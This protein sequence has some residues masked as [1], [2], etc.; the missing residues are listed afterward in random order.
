MTVTQAAIRKHLS[1]LTPNQR[2]QLASLATPRVVEPYTKHIPHPTQQVFLSLNIEE[3]LYGGAAGG[4]KSDALLMAALQY[5]DVPGY[6]AL[7]LRRTWPDLVLPGAIMDRTKQWLL[8]TDARP[9]DGGRSWT[10]PSGAKLQFGYLA[11]D[12]DKY[13][14]QSAEFQ[15]VGF[16]ELTQWP[17]ETTYDYLFSRIRRPAINCLGCNTTLG[18]Y[19]RS[20]G[21]VQYKH[22]TQEGR[23]RCKK[24]FPDPKVLSQYPQSRD[25]MSVFDIPLRMRAATNPGGRG[26]HWVKARFVDP[27]TRARGA[28]F[29]PARLVDNPSLDRDSYRKALEH[30]NPI[31]KE[32]L[33][34]GDW[35]ITEGGDMFERTDFKPTDSMM[36]PDA[37]RV[38]FWDMAATDSSGD[39]TV[40]VLCA[41]H[42]DKFCIEHVVRAQ[43]RPH[44]VENLVL[45]TAMSDGINVHVRMEQEPGSSGLAVVS[46]FKRHVLPGFNFDGIRSTGNKTARASALASYAKKDGL[47]LMLIGSWNRVFLDEMEAFPNGANDDIVDG[48]SGGFNYLMFGRKRARLLA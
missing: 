14:Y 34:N 43:K 11:N 33:L 29:V 1:K 16:D 7:L 48:A 31:D 38:R 35:D 21:G 19:R 41:V 30:L 24:L 26:A 36:P 2:A 32:R 40:G 9:H 39:Y 4:G 6:A 22:T 18:R 23:K 47:V 17:S 37:K 42:E 44:E 28:V 8:A 27:R 5:V 20:D 10:F 13:R 25:G 46:S 45:R 3:A 12:D 15:F